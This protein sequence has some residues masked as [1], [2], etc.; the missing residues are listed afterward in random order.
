MEDGDS[1]VGR[2][3]AYLLPTWRVAVCALAVSVCLGGIGIASAFGGKKTMRIVFAMPSTGMAH[4]PGL[5]KPVVIE[6]DQLD[7]ADAQTLERLID[8]ARF[9]DQ[10]AKVDG[11]RGGR[12]A[13]TRVYT[14]TIEQNGKRHT[15]QV[16]E[17]LNEP[18]HRNLRDLIRFLEDKAKTLR[19]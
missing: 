18:E 16:G 8:E 4:F 5:A 1:K 14:I 10:P 12:T 7:E 13:D 11:S 9:F 15:V 6:S 2:P 17:P 3:A 19:R